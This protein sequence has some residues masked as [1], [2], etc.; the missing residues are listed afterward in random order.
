MEIITLKI[1]N[2][3][4]K[5]GII[6]AISKD[7]VISLLCRGIFDPKSKNALLNNPLTIADVETSEGR[8]KYPVV[9]SSLLVTSPINP[10]ASL[11]YM[12]VLMLINESVNYLLSEDE[13]PSIYDY[14]KRTIEELKNG[15]NPLKISIV[16][17]AKILRLSGYDFGVNECVM[18]GGKKNIVTFSFNDGGFICANCYTPDIPKV[19]N[20]NQMLALREAFLT[21]ESSLI[22]TEISDEEMMFIL[23]KFKEFIHDSYGYSLKSLDLLK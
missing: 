17:L 5:D 15:T 1:T 10:H 6:E 13:K 20:K 4:E 21:D 16:F 3:K 8:Y 12:A 22:H 14:L 19:F 18:C 23:H 7:G 2:Y 11:T 9:S